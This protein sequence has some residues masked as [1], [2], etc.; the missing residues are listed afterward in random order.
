MHRCPR[1]SAPV[2]AQV[3]TSVGTGPQVVTVST[4]AGPS[5]QFLITVSATQP[6][7]LAPAGF[8]IGGRQ[9]AAAFLPDGSTF[10]LPIASIPSTP[11]RPA[12][13]GETI[14]LYGIG[15]G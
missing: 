3:P 9:Y 8:R 1:R 13:P 11:S 12:K 6:G 2:N 5:A 15:F 7:L 14:V 4:S 10:V